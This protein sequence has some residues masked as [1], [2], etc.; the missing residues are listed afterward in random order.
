[1]KKLASHFITFSVLVV[2]LFS[3]NKKND[4]KPE[5][6]QDPNE[7][8]L[9]TTVKLILTEQSSGNV[10]VFKFT[11]LDGPGAA[12]PTKDNIVLEANK[13]YHGQIILL[14]QT[15]SPVDSVSNEVYDERDDHQFFFIVTSAN[16]TVNYTDYDTH[17]VPVGLRPD[18]L[19]GNV[20]TGKLKLILKHQ[21]GMKPTSGM[22][23]I[24]K[25][26]TDVEVVFNVTIN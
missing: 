26:E 5:D 19:T 9:I 16:L 18:F 25:G 1:M 10:S 7:T 22:G 20:S 15:K 3:C 17:G 12:S 24:S 14:D 6:P 21:P 2:L 4:P 13:T 8:E 23:D 11:D